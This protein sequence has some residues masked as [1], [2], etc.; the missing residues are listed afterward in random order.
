MKSGLLLLAL[1][2]SFGAPSPVAAEAESS[3]ALILHEGSVARR[4]LVALGRDLEVRGEA[5]SDVAALDGSVLVTGRVEGDVIVLGGGARLDSTAR[6]AGDVFTLGGPIEAEPGAEIGGRSVSYPTASAAW[7][8]LLEGPSIGLSPFSPL[9]LG[10][11][12]ALLTA[13][14]ALVL[15]FFSTSGR[16][17]MGTSQV[18]R[19]EPFR[20]F[21]VGVVGILALVLTT[22][23]FSAFAAALVG[24][25]LLVLVVVLALVLKLWGMVAVFHALGSWIGR[26]MGNRP[27][28]ALNA[29]TLGLVV[30]G[31]IKFIP[32]VGIWAWSIATFIGVGAALSTKFG[33]REPWLAPA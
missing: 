10:G 25:P 12:L 3:A 21:F 4:Q 27:M 29:A 20:N 2:I 9:V 14:L 6:V 16:Q 24:V 8:T 28:R 23:L 22:L 33:R 7:L 18:I 13:W 32:Y 19:V 30:L 15:L 26:R 11:K 1:L 17:V 5:R 31:V